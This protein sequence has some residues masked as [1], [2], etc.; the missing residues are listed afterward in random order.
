MFLKKTL[1]LSCICFNVSIARRVLD[2]GQPYF[3]AILL[4]NTNN[5]SK[6]QDKN[7]NEEDEFDVNCLSEEFS[8]VMS[9]AMWA[10]YQSITVILLLNIL[11]AMMNTTYTRIWK[12]RQALKREEIIHSYIIILTIQKLDDLNYF[13][14]LLSLKLSCPVIFSGNTPSLSMR[15]NI[16]AREPCCLRPS[17]LSSTS[18]NVFITRGMQPVGARGRTNTR[19]TVTN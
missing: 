16:S 13:E 7:T 11:I 6:D 3:A 15:S 5:C 19:D 14:V 18:S 9:L 1:K 12:I 2:A 8:H 10:V 17:E 4:N